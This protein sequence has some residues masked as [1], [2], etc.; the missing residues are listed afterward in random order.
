[1]FPIVSA[2][3]DAPTFVPV[4]GQSNEL[5]IDVSSRSQRTE[6]DQGEVVSIVHASAGSLV[7]ILPAEVI[8]TLLS[9]AP[10]A[11]LCIVS[12]IDRKGSA[13]PF[14][15]EHDATIPAAMSP[16]Q[17]LVVMVRSVHGQGARVNGPNAGSGG[18]YAS[19]GSGFFA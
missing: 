6:R 10:W 1:M 4:S 8:S 11:V 15:F 16:A 12:F 18:S 19:A 13:S 9:A 14:A 7:G 3:T 5:A 2:P 17:I